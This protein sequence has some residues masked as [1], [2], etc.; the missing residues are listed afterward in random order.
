MERSFA[1]TTATLAF[2]VTTLR[3][4]IRGDE[5]LPTANLGLGLAVVFMLVGFVLGVL[6]RVM[7]EECVRMQPPGAAPETPPT[8]GG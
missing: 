4:A 2:G 3:G 8:N 6:A 7:V 1:A 5:F